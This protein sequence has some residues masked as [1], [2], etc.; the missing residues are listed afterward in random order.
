MKYFKITRLEALVAVLAIGLIAFG[1]VAKAQTT[2]TSSTGASSNASS[3]TSSGSQAISGG[4]AGGGGGTGASNFTVNPTVSINSNGSDLSRAVPTAIAPQ[5]TVLSGAQSCL[6]S[7]SGGVGVQ[8]F[9]GS[10]GTL[11][12]DDACDRRVTAILAIKMKQPEIGQAIL[13]G[14]PK[15]WA[16]AQ[17]VSLWTRSTSVCHNDQPTSAGEIDV[18][19]AN[20]GETAYSYPVRKDDDLFD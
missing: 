11:V 15:Y 13:C 6:K 3:Q 4:G 18:N 2:V 1:S 7:K 19:L 8:G 5:M 14:D 20:A 12:M 16:S 10:Y 17:R 9:G